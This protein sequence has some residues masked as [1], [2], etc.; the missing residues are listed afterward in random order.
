MRLLHAT[1]STWL[2]AMATVL[3]MAP[4]RALAAPGDVDNDGDVD[5]ADYRTLHQCMV[6]PGSTYSLPACAAVNFLDPPAP[7]DTDVDLRDFRVFANI[8]NP[9]IP[10]PGDKCSASILLLDGEGVFP[11]DNTKA[12]TDGLSFPDCVAHQQDQIDN[13]LWYCWD[14]T[15][16]GMVLVETCGLTEVDT[17]IAVYSGCTCP[18]GAA[19]LIGCGDD[20]CGPKPALQ[21]RATFQA[22]KGFRYLIR[23]G[24]YPLNKPGAGSFRISCGF[25]ACPSAGGCESAHAAGMRGCSDAACCNRVCAVDSFCCEDTWDGY[26]AA[27]ATGICYTGFDSCGSPIAGSCG[28]VHA[29]PG[30]SDADC[31]EAVCSADPDCCIGDAGWADFCVEAEA[32]VCR[33][34]CETSASSCFAAHASPGCNDPACCAQV[35]PRQPF[36]CQSA[37]DASCAE[38]ADQHCN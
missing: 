28:T 25:D 11:F 33:G 27:E 30:C 19:R 20:G 31:C 9:P 14:S 29:S 13:D 6:G 35:C 8:F 12:S 37:W 22:G 15:C 17:K 3:A 4:A 36:C 21:S 26:C 16:N 7:S 23:I 32:V 18:A 10:P 5:L 1:T 38:L 34:A 2:I 24:N